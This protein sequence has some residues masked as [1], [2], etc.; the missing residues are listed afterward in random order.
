MIRLVNVLT[1]QTDLSSHQAQRNES[2]QSLIREYEEFE[3]CCEFGIKPWELDSI[4]KVQVQ[5]WLMFMAAKRK[6][7]NYI[8][9]L[10]LERIAGRPMF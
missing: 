1:G 2:L 9:K 7:R 6:E 8:H 3:L 10:Y 5:K 4:D